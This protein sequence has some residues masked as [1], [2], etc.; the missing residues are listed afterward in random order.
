MRIIF[1]RFE[2]FLNW[3][4][5]SDAVK[6]KLVNKIYTAVISHRGVELIPVLSSKN[7][8]S[9]LIEVSDDKDFE[10]IMEWLKERGFEKIPFGIVETVA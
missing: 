2:D 10:K 5:Q 8:H 9:I 4:N 6:R 1:R 3:V 7:L